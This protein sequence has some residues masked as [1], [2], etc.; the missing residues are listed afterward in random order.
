MSPVEDNP[1]ILR[2]FVALDRIDIIEN[3]L[4]V[5]DDRVQ[6]RAN[7]VTHAGQQI[8]HAAIGFAQLLFGTLAFVDVLEKPVDPGD[9]AVFLDRQADGAHPADPTPG[10]NDLEF[11]VV[12][13]ALLG[14]QAEDTGDGFAA[15]AFVIEID[16]RREVRCEG[17]VDF[18]N[19]PGHARPGHASG[20]QFDFPGSDPSGFAGA[21]QEIVSVFEF[22]PDPGFTAYVPEDAG[23]HRGVDVRSFQQNRAFHVHGATG[24]RDQRQP[25]AF[26][27]L[28][29]SLA[30]AL[31]QA[32][33]VFAAIGVHGVGEVQAPV[34]FLSGSEV[35]QPGPVHFQ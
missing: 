29:V 15:F 19:V 18:V 23:R 8:G 20:F 28:K 3:Q 13:P 34:I 11:H 7:L 25:D 27:E 32:V 10:G 21:L 4:R 33:P 16:P 12:G 24:R 17:F 35:A 6:W 5:T 14:A 1:R 2:D 30:H 26:L 9:L 22:A 31:Q